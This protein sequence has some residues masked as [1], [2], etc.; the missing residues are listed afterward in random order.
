MAEQ[1]NYAEWWCLDGYDLS[2]VSSNFGTE[3]TI[4]DEKFTCFPDPTVTA[5]TG[6]FVKRLPGVESAQI[7]NTGY[8][9]T[10]INLPAVEAA[11][12]GSP[13][14]SKG[15]G[16]ALGDGVLLFS[17]KSGSFNYGGEVG[18]VIPFSASILSDGPVVYGS[19]FEFG[20]KTATGNGTS[21]TMPAVTAGKSLYIHVHV[22]SVSGTSSPTLTL[23]YERSAN[24]TYS[25]AVT[26]HTFTAF[27][28]IGAQRAIKTSAISDLNHRFRWTVSGTDPI[29]QVRLAA[30]VR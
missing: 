3:R 7:Q 1:I 28:A 17:G 11:I 13:I 23:I 10:T 15:D 19:L 9:D 5:P 25:D 20:N 21:R 30:G 18:K 16:R 6:I 27:T 8:L 4:E 22:T 14:S 12:P 24:G 29:F 26:V 2:G